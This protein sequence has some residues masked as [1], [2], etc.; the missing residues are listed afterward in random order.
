MAGEQYFTIP[1]SCTTLTTWLLTFADW[2]TENNP[3]SEIYTT[4]FERCK[5]VH[6]LLFFR[7]IVQNWSEYK[8]RV[9]GG[10]GVL[11]TDIL[12]FPQFLSHQETRTAS[13]STNSIIGI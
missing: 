13:R 4:Q 11:H 3:I 12:L 2:I 6:S 8:M 7:E 10:G 5:T 1:T 9:G